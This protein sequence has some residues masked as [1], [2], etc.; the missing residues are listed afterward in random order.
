MDKFYSEKSKARRAL[1]AIGEFALKSATSSNLLFQGED[2]RWGFN[3]E[4]A[5]AAQTAGEN[6]AKEITAPIAPVRTIVKGGVK[7]SVNN[8]K[9]AP[10]KVERTVAPAPALPVAESKHKDEHNCPN[11]KATED[12]VWANEGVSLYCHRCGTT[13]SATTGRE[14][15]TGYTRP[16]A[17]KGY[18]IQ[19]NRPE[20][21]GV[22]RPSDNTTCGKVWAAF[23]ANPTIASKQLGELA[24]ANGWNKNN[25]SCEFY[26]WRK[27]NGIK[28]RSN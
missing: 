14:I 15:K 8:E 2:G 3:V 24:E 25:V 9:V 13:Y 6:A 22:K 4:A 7:V 19:K 27:F 16:N 10:A 12:Q 21:N 11:C 20:Q 23:D 1:N 26:Q 18:T 5:E 28:G 17:P